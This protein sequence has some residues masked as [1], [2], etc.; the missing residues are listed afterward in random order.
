[1]ATYKE[2]KGVTVQALDDDPVEF[3]GTWSSG[4]NINTARSYLGSAGIKT[5]LLVFGGVEPAYSN[6]TESWNGSS[7]TESNDLNTARS[8]MASGGTYTAAFSA[9]GRSSTP[10]STAATEEWNGTSWAEGNDLNLER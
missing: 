7:W 10:D 1:M 3:V 5:A 2:I 9:G 6:K 4:T 8:A